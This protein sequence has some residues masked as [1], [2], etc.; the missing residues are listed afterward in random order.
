MVNGPTTLLGY[1]RAMTPAVRLAAVDALTQLG[2]AKQLPSATLREF[3]VT[4]VE[5]LD[6]AGPAVRAAA[7]A[8]CGETH[9]GWCAKEL[10]TCLDDSEP[11]VRRNSLEALTQLRNSESVESALRFLDG[12]DQ[13]VLAALKCLE[14]L[15]APSQ[16]EAVMTAAMRSR[17]TEILQCAAELL[18]KWDRLPE[19][20]RLQGASGVI[21]GWH[22]SEPFSEDEAMR[23]IL[24]ILQRS[25]SVSS[26]WRKVCAT[27]TD[28]RANFGPAEGGRISLGSRRSSF[29]NQP[30]RN[31]E[32]R[33]AER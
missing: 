24:L 22:V 17:S 31:S 30:T 26:G 13:D 4:L 29:L 12:N 2:S 33:A 25:A 5:L 10:L 7:A 32:R 27:N 21:L 19:L 11:L 1:L 15:G 9:V 3:E 23:T 14:Q 20:A 18:L 16:G 6:D 28:L 8:A